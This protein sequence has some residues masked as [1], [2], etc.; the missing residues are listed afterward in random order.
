MPG[1]YPPGHD[2]MLTT[3]PELEEELMGRKVVVV[4]G[5]LYYES[6]FFAFQKELDLCY[7]FG[8]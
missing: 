8:E 3:R 6:F 2:L 5:F 7:H 1:L 4:V